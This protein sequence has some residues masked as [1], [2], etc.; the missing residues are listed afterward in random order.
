[1]YHLI[2]GELVAIGIFDLTNKYFN[3]AYFVY[4]SKYSYL[5]LGVVGAIMEI[6]F[7]KKL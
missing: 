1:M 2:D 5:N 4:K 7:C 6:E 3:S